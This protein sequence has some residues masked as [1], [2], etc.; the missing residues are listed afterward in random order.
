[1]EVKKKKKVIVG[2]WEAGEKKLKNH[3]FPILVFF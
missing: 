2:E 1:M 3:G